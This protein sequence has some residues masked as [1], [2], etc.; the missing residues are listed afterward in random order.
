MKKFLS[1]LGALALLVSCST[2]D[3][4]NDSDNGNKI[5]LPKKVQYTNSDHPEKNSTSVITYNGKKIV[6]VTE[7]EER[8]DYIYE[9]N[10]IVKTI[11]YDITYNRNDKKSE[12]SYT[13][14][15]GKLSSSISVSNF[16]SEYPFGEYQSRSVYI[17]NADGTIKKES[18]S[19]DKTTGVESKASG[20]VLLTFANG[21]LSTEVTT[22]NNI[23]SN[24]YDYDTK[25]NAFKNVSG[26][27]SLLDQ[28]INSSINNIK[29]K[30][31]WIA[32]LDVKLGN[33]STLSTSEYDYNT[34]DYPNKK[35]SYKEDGTVMEIIE[36][37]Y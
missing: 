33:L 28:E 15:D 27:S 23:V 3:N 10:V 37:T 4:D 22:A 18:Y 8:T 34:N 9:G 21:N 26:F 25:N 1:L 32:N 35:T 17:Y 13:Y 19:T 31:L 24:I 16:T 11:T 6:S 36:Y 14:T 30:T 20:E 29:T 5:T 7:E 2:T 12:K